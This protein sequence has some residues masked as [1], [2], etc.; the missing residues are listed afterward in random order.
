MRERGPAPRS[1]AGALTEGATTARDLACWREDSTLEGR[2]PRPS[3]VSG[4]SGLALDESESC[5][6]TQL[7]TF[8]LCFDGKL[9]ERM[10]GEGGLLMGSSSVKRSS[11]GNRL[12]PLSKAWV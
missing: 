7:I 9:G 8:F 10:D 6:V 4:V 11:A 1:D 2:W 5:T 12:R 3:G